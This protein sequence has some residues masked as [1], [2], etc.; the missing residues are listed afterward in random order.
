MHPRLRR[1][2]QPQLLRLRRG[3]GH[4]G[5]L[6][7][8]TAPTKVRRISEGHMGKVDVELARQNKREG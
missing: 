3:R 2:H 7:S 5:T 6:A 4:A 8:K 1:F